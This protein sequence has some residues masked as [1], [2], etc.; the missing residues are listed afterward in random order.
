MIAA[1]VRV[2]CTV[3]H[4]LVCCLTSFVLMYNYARSARDK[5]DEDDDG[6]IGVGLIL[7]DLCGEI[8]G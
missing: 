1:G 3:A 8:V 6:R 4:A 7:E 2:I 5:N